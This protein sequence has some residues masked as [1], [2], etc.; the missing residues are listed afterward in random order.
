MTDEPRDKTGVDDT[1]KAASDGVSDTPQLP[2]YPE[3]TYLPARW[4]VPTSG[5]LA[6]LEAL[7]EAITC[8]V[9]DE[10]TTALA[11]TVTTDE[12]KGLSFAICGDCLCEAIAVQ[13]GRRHVLAGG[14]LEDLTLH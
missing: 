11:L 8:G 3:G 5:G 1:S 2:R 10:R 7:A 13:I 14:E 4:G 9:C 6:I 12:G